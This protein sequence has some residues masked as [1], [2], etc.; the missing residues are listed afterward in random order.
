MRL[1]AT[2]KEEVGTNQN[3]KE[4]EDQDKGFSTVARKKRSDIE[5][6]MPCYFYSL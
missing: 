2:R 3:W 5:I 4:N 6:K 1:R